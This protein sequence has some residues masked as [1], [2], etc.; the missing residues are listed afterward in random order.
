M[1]LFSKRVNECQGDGFLS[2][3]TQTGAI[4]LAM[5]GGPNL[6]NRCRFHQSVPPI[7]AP[8]SGLVAPISSILGLLILYG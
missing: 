6:T 7:L 8:N 4:K 2:V 1:Y 3:G 5:A